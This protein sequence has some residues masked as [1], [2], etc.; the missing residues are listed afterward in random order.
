MLSSMYRFQNFHGTYYIEDSMKKIFIH[1]PLTDNIIIP[2]DITHHI[3]HVFRHDMRKPVTVSGSDGQTGSYLITAE[4]DGAAYAQL[5]E[6][7]PSQT[8]MSRVILVQSLLKGEKLEWVLQKATELNV[9]AVYLVA[10]ANN[11]V[12]YDDKKLMSKASRWEKIMQEASQQC[13]R[14]QLPTLVVDQTLPQVLD[15]ESDA[16]Q[17]VAYENE[18]GRTLK[19]A[20]VDF[21]Q[22]TLSDFNQ[23]TVENSNNSNGVIIAPTQPTVLIC[24]GPEGG[25]Q[26]KEIDAMSERGVESVTL[27]N[28]ILRAETAA[29][30]SIAMINYELE[31]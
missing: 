25:F 19:D 20:L 18:T 26:Q 17:L 10:T 9:D 21:K 6:L 5:C 2:K 8:Q 28:T 24:I 22:K 15:I 4:I 29:I 12:K 1:T 13:G 27:G 16:L 3:L 23:T 31:L 30:S 14:N 7:L 11:V